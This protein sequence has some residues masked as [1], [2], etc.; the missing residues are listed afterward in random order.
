MKRFTVLIAL[1][2]LAVAGTGYATDR[3]L[4]PQMEPTTVT[5]VP[6]L[7][8]QAIVAAGIDSTIDASVTAL[9]SNVPAML[10]EEIAGKWGLVTV[11][12]LAG[13]P[14]NLFLRPTAPC[15]IVDTRVDG[16]PFV[17][18]EVRKYLLPGGVRCGGSIPQSVT[19]PSAEGVVVLLDVR[20]EADNYPWSWGDNGPVL[21]FIGTAYSPDWFTMQGE[22]GFLFAL[23]EGPFPDTAVGKIRGF[24]ALK[25]LPGGFTSLWGLETQVKSMWSRSDFRAHVTID[26]VGY[27]APTFRQ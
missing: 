4:A 17:N 16:G 2:L 6:V 12:S 19:Y 26:I 8:R 10:T 1:A 24:V 14:K 22:R 25:R 20:M 3:G 9:S 23:N 27:A 15:R 13:V 18:G 11:I 21:D 7:D 5:V